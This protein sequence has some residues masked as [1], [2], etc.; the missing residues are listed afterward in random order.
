MPSKPSYVSGQWNFTCDL[1]GKLE[2]S[3]KAMKTWDGRYVCSRHREVRNP[4]DFVRGVK[5]DQTVPWS[6][7]EPPDQ[8]ITI[9]CT[10]QSNN[11]IPSYGVPGCMIPSYVNT[12]FTPVL[13]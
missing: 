8:F 13:P 1:C 4:Q 3:G 6:R 2:K 5:D 9:Q 12:A 11:A 10:M 7:P